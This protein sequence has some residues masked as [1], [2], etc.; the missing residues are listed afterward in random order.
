MLAS[1]V[2]AADGGANRIK[3]L[4]L[5]DQDEEKMV[6]LFQYRQGSVV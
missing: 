3:D 1:Y 5:S 4:N 2:V 6:C